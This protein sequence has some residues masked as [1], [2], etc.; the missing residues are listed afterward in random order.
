ML[1]ERR[2][3]ANQVAEK[4]FAAEAAIDAAVAAVAKLTAVMPMARQDARLSA[5]IGQDA[6]MAAM[7]T[8]QQLV[9]ARAS[10]IETHAHL[11]TAQKQVGLGAVNFNG[12]CPPDKTAC[13]PAEELPATRHLTVAA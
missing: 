3:A 11:R 5:M 10:I 4:L 6:L 7:A 8:C 2:I 12:N 1:N 13:L 9:Q